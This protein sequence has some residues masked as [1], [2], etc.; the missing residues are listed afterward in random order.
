MGEVI[1]F[2]ED[3]EYLWKV[4]AF[5][6]TSYFLLMNNHFLYITGTDHMRTATIVTAMSSWNLSFWTLSSCRI[7]NYSQTRYVPA[8]FDHG[9]PG[10]SPG[11]SPIIPRGSLCLPLRWLLFVDRFL[12]RYPRTTRSLLVHSPQYRILRSRWGRSSLIFARLA[13][14]R[15]VEQSFVRRW[16]KVPAVWFRVFLAKNTTSYMW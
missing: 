2:E 11:P 6:S 13:I 16:C 15:Y 12:P 4:M 14:L 8:N 10:K 5:R 9:L 3:E 7:Q 1:G